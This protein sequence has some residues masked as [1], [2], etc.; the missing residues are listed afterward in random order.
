MY[1]RQLLYCFENGKALRVAL[2]NYETKS[3]RRKL[4]SAYSDRS[5]LVYVDHLANE[6]VDYAFIS[7]QGK[8]A[9]VSSDLIPIKAT[10]TSQGVQVMRLSLIHI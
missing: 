6:T 4:V 10:R 9:V 1:K 2:S 8:L 3:K 5:P 7:T